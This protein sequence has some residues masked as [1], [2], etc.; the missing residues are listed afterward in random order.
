MEEGGWRRRILDYHM[1]GVFFDYSEVF[2]VAKKFKKKNGKKKRERGTRS[3][4]R[5]EIISHWM[6]S[7]LEG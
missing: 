6:A 4:K 5:M 7:L 1:A 3:V 2:T